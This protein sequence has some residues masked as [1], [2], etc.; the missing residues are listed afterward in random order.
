MVRHNLPLRHLG[1]TAI[2]VT[3][4]GLGGAWLGRTEA[5]V[6][7]ELGIATVLQALNLGI[8]LIDTSA[9]YMGGSR[10]ERI[11]G[12]ALERWYELGGRRQDLV[13]ST[14]TGTRDPQHNNYTAAATRRSIE[15]SLELLKTEYLDVCLVHDPDDLAPVLA[16]NGAWAELKHLKAEGLIRAIGLG[17]RS[18]EFHRRMMATAECDVVLTHSDYHLLNQ[19]ALEGVLKP[20]ERYGVGV[21]N[22]TPLA[23]GLLAGRDPVVVAEEQEAHTRRAPTFADDVRKA[24]ALWHW[25]NERG[26]DLLALNLQFCAREPRIAATLLGA[27]TPGQI[28]RDVAALTAEIPEEVW[29]ALPAQLEA[30]VARAS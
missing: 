17:V 8:N 27:S 6:D 30:F 23:H 19:S 7:E 2:Q 25:A 20:A 21:L 10:S 22:G 24:D 3:P 5:G 11:I 16:S 14:K 28:E 4:I 26:V 15:K 18:H 1:I 13:L 9:G 12:M 29:V